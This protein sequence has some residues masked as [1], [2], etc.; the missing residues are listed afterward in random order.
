MFFRLIYAIALYISLKI[1]DFRQ[2]CKLFFY[3]MLLDIDLEIFAVSIS[4]SDQHG[5]V[6]DSA[7]HRCSLRNL[8]QKIIRNFVKN[9]VWKSLKILDF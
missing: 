5:D 1:A 6:V 8:V 7:Y 3:M 2:C 9:N 4:A